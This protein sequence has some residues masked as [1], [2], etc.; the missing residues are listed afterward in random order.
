MDVFG[1]NIWWYISAIVVLLILWGVARYGVK[2]PTPKKK[3]K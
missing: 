3:K 1:L 2:K